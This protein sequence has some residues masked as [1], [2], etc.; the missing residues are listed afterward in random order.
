MQLKKGKN[1]LSFTQTVPDD[2]LKTFWQRSG[3]EYGG[4]SIH[5]FNLTP[6]R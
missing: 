2:Y 4:V 1:V 5:S 6:T 3:P